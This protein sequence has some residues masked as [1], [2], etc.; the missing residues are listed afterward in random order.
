VADEVTSMR[1]Y[2]ERRRR[3]LDVVMNV[4][5]RPPFV[6]DAGPMQCNSLFL[7]RSSRHFVIHIEHDVLVCSHRS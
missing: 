4:L 1:H 2:G 3:S 6:I 7:D 5:R